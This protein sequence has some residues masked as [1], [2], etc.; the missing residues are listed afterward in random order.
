[1]SSRYSLHVTSEVSKIVQL[2]SERCTCLLHFHHPLIGGLQLRHP[3]LFRIWRK[4]PVWVAEARLLRRE[5]LVEE[6]LGDA[7]SARQRAGAG[8]SALFGEKTACLFD[9]PGGAF[10][11]RK[12]APPEPL[13]SRSPLS[14]DAGSCGFR[15]HQSSLSQQSG[16]IACVEGQQLATR[17]WATGRAP[18]SPR[19]PGSWRRNA[20]MAAS[21]TAPRFP[22]W[23][24]SDHNTEVGS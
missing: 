6:C 18:E 20:T 15:R 12:P 23:S 10:A 16:T 3:L 14:V 5:V 2:S 22:V 9:Q 21:W 24:A 4:R 7:E 11:R 8:A 17:R 1:V 19:F 13:G